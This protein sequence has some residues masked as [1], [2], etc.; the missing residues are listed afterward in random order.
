MHSIIS[1]LQATNV[2]Y[3]IEQHIKGINFLEKNENCIAK[4]YF[5][6]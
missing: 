5:I 2:Y 1:K 4:I 3:L 6:S